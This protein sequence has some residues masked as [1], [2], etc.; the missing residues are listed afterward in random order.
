MGL[1]VFTVLLAFSACNAAS[2]DLPNVEDCEN[3]DYQDCNTVQPYEAKLQINFSITSKIKS[4]P[5]EVY[6]GYVEDNNLFF[7]DTAYSAFLEYD[8]PVD[9]YYT[10]KAIYQM[11]GK[12]LKVIDGGNIKTHS[13]SVCDSTCWSVNDLNL[14]VII[15]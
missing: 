8:V 3:Y 6:K 10:V 12:T 13:K 14:S 5:F 9:N 2:S 15:K 1:I 4:V 11:E 7:R